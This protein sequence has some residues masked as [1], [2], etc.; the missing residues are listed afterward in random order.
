MPVLFER[1]MHG[2]ALKFVSL[3]ENTFFCAQAAC[4]MGVYTCFLSKSFY[5][6][7]VVYLETLL[8]R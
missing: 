8:Y 3:K 7:S 1:Y 5:F 6:K 4:V 2:L